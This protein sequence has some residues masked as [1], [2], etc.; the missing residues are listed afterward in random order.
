MRFFL[1]NIF[2][3]CIVF[4]HQKAFASCDLGGEILRGR[5]VRSKIST[6]IQGITQ[7]GENWYISNRLGIYKIPVEL[8]INNQSLSNNLLESFL[9]QIF[10]R[11]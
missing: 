11:A 5:S 8:K 3:Y 4:S 9:K 1:I 10:Q 6:D 7:D 2:I